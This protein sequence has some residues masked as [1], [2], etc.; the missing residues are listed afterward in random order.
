[1]GGAKIV[2]LQQLSSNQK[3]L[4]CGSSRFEAK[5]RSSFTK[6]QNITRGQYYENSLRFDDIIHSVAVFFCLLLLSN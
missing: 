2:M 5:S 4:R 1:V 6:R 3:K